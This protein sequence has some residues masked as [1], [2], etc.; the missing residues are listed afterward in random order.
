VRGG[1]AAHEVIAAEFKRY[2]GE[3][4]LVEDVDAVAR[5]LRP[6]ARRLDALRARAVACLDPSQQFARAAADVEDARTHRQRQ[7]GDR[8]VDRR[9]GQRIG[10]SHAAM[11]DRGDRRAV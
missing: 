4:G 10:E 2:V 6:P 8:V 5:H 11:R 9:L 3:L 7:R 1:Q